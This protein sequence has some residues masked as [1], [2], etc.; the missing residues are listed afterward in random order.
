MAAIAGG[1]GAGLLVGVW[2]GRRTR[3]RDIRIY[4]GRGL[5]GFKVPDQEVTIEFSAK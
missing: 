1:V 5:K 2:A 4:P 3:G